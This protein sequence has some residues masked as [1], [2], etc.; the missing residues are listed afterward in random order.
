MDITRSKKKRK[1]IPIVD[2]LNLYGCELRPELEY[3]IPAIEFNIDS[4]IIWEEPN[5][6]FAHHDILKL[7]NGHYL[8]RTETIQNGPVPNG[9][10]TPICYALYGPSLCNGVTEFFPWHGDKIIEWDN[11]T[12]EIVWEWNTFE[13]FNMNDYDDIGG[14]TSSNGMGRIICISGYD[15]I[16]SSR[17]SRGYRII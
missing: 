4:E 12:K 5:N 14:S 11:E 10:W 1:H 15:G 8:G 13:N 9:P 16:P 17:D 2:N 6:E 7:P 3:N